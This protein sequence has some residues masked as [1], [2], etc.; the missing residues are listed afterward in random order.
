MTCEGLIADEKCEAAAICRLVKSTDRF[1]QEYEFN[2]NFKLS[3][4]DS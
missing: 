2:R 3:E 1:V 4:Y